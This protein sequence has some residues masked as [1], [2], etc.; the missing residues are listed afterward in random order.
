MRLGTPYACPVHAPT[1]AVPPDL[2]ALSRSV[3]V[4]ASSIP[5]HCSPEEA[6]TLRLSTVAPSALLKVARSI[7]LCLCEVLDQHHLVEVAYR[8]HIAGLESELSEASQRAGALQALVVASDAVTGRLE[9]R[10]EL[11]NCVLRDQLL[12]TDRLSSECRDLQLAQ[13]LFFMKDSI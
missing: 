3:R 10:V 7:Q 12:L 5:A 11:L 2:A 9:R 4:V 6:S 1:L 8:Q 13:Q